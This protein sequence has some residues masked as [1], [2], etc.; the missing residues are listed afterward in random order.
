MDRPRETEVP[1]LCHVRGSAESRNCG[2]S[3]APG[4]LSPLFR[5]PV[6][7]ETPLPFPSVDSVVG[8]VGTYVFMCMYVIYIIHRHNT[9]LIT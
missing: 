9:N 4:I 2:E 6:P 8:Y 1:E 7:P 5:T 3:W